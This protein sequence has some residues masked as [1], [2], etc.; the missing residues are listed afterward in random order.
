MRSLRR[1]RLMRPVEG[2]AGPLPRAGVDAVCEAGVPVAGPIRSFLRDPP[3][4]PTP[5]RGT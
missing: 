3:G 4:F 2:A 5:R 1:Y